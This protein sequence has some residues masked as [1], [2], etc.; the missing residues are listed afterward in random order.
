M[1]EGGGLIKRVRALYDVGPVTYPAYPDTN[2]EVAK[3][4]YQQWVTDTTKADELESRARAELAAARRSVIE[5][6]REFLR[7]RGY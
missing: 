7:N 2:A 4:S 5:K 3:R 6:N 1:D